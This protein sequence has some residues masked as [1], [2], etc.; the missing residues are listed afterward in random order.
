MKIYVASSW[1][2][3][4]Q[5]EIVKSLRGVGHE[6]YDFRTASIDPAATEDD[7]FRWSEIDRDW[8]QWTALEYVHALQTP[9]AQKGFHND[10]RGMDWADVCVLVLPSGR[11]AHLEAGFMAGQGKPVFICT[12]NGEEPEL[13][14]LLCTRVVW[15]T[16]MLLAALDE[17]AVHKDGGPFEVQPARKPPKRQPVAPIVPPAG[18]ANGGAAGQASAA[19]TQGQGQTPA[20]A[21]ADGTA[22]QGQALPLPQIGC[23]YRYLGRHVKVVGVKPDHVLVE[24]MDG[25]DIAPLIELDQFM[26]H[27]LRCNSLGMVLRLSSKYE[28]ETDGW[29]KYHKG[30]ETT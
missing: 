17:Y 7:G 30:E 5:P 10:K 8:Q 16:E 19:A 29:K 14:A 21:S 12:R 4:M 15:N 18:Y 3:T 1:R 20:P 11:S 2:N 13:M 24:A 6:V 25:S 28:T 26:R 27:A 9:L 22:P 23:H